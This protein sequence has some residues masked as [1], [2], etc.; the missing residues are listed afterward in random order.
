MTAGCRFAILDGANQSGAKVIAKC[1]HCERGMSSIKVEAIQIKAGK[2]SW[3]GVA[4]CCPS[5]DCALSVM[6]DQISLK[7]DVVAEVL[8]GLGREQ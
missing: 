8:Q 2:S 6:I 7:D 4:Y 5:C 3:N 1:P